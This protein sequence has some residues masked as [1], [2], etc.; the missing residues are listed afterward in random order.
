MIKEKDS[1]NPK[2]E[3]KVRPKKKAVLC[4]FSQIYLDGRQA[5]FF[6]QITS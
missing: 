5:R 1:K 4:S 6:S 3:S 2:N